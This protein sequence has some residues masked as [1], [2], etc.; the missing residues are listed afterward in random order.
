MA[1]RHGH[2]IKP[3]RHPIDQRL[4]RQPEHRGTPNASLFGSSDRERRPTKMTG[5]SKPHLDK[6]NH[7]PFPHDQINLAHSEPDISCDERQA[8]L[9]QIGKRLVFSDLALTLGKS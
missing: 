1:G 9:D 8:L 2:H 6:Q 3:T 5:L 7:L 4:L